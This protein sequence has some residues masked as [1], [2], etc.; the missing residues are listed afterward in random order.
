MY[1]LLI[2]LE[3]DGEVFFFALDEETHT[4]VCLRVK[5]VHYMLFARIQDEAKTY[6]ATALANHLRANP[7]SAPVCHDMKTLYPFSGTTLKPHKV[8]VLY[9]D[10]QSTMRYAKAILEKQGRTCVLDNS[11]TRV[12]HF[13]LDRGLHPHGRFELEKSEAATTRVTNSSRELVIDA[14]DIVNVSPP[15]A[16]PPKYLL[17][18]A[19][20]MHGLFDAQ[21][22][23]QMF[24]RSFEGEAVLFICG[25]CVADMDRGGWNDVRVFQ[26]PIDLATAVLDDIRKQDPVGLFGY[27]IRYGMGVR[28]LIVYCRKQGVFPET[29]S[30]FKDKYAQQACAVEFCKHTGHAGHTSLPG[31]IVFDIWLFLRTFDRSAKQYSVEYNLQRHKLAYAMDTPRLIK[32]A[33]GVFGVAHRRLLVQIEQSVASALDVITLLRSQVAS[34]KMVET[35][36]YFSTESFMNIEEAQCRSLS[37]VWRLTLWH[38]GLQAG[39][40]PYM[41]PYGE[42]MV[43]AKTEGGSHTDVGEEEDTEA[44]VVVPGLLKDVATFDYRSCYTAAIVAHN[45]CFTTVCRSIVCTAE[46]T[47]V[48]EYQN[49]GQNFSRV[50]CKPSRRRGIIPTELERLLE[51]REAYRRDGSDLAR[52]HANAIK[53]LANALWGLLGSRD[54]TFHDPGIAQAITG[55]T[56]KLFHHAVNTARRLSLR[57]VYGYS[58]S[59]LVQRTDD[60]DPRDTDWQNMVCHEINKD[61]PSPIIIKCDGVHDILLLSLNNMF[62]LQDGQ[63]SVKG[64][65]AATYTNPGCVK[66]TLLLLATKVL[67]GMDRA[68]FQDTVSTLKD[69]FTRSKFKLHEYQM[70]KHYLQ[71]GLTGDLQRLF[72]RLLADGVPIQPY[73]EMTY[74]HTTHGPAIGHDT[75]IE[76]IDSDIYWGLVKSDIDKINSVVFGCESEQ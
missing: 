60:G 49:F 54:F 48:V 62:M 31:R 51:K 27:D 23:P 40:Y 10:T 2:P 1:T 52:M 53:L 15:S 46:D 25:A 12:Q 69:L 14:M 19:Y 41:D 32:S 13:L 71:F 29:I 67:Q 59:V 9:F 35:L 21:D 66:S 34:W 55:L 45:L 42:G 47:T 8:V 57:V 24:M 43:A 33:N 11:L 64:T 73:G 6:H 3:K 5:N 50:I 28:A 58:D 7:N 72:K 70:V 44:L 22:A 63:I 18:R 30:H 76:D 17:E 20:L 26:E 68:A 16:D 56:R 38:R 37:Y 65:A 74:W 4:Q 39:Y 75:R 36:Y 61:L